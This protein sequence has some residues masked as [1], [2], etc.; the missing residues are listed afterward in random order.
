MLYHCE[1]LILC[2]MLYC[3]QV[4]KD[5]E[6]PFVH[7]L[8]VI[9]RSGLLSTLHDKAWVVLALYNVV[10]CSPVTDPDISKQFSHHNVQRWFG[11][12]PRTVPSFEAPSLALQNQISL[13]WTSK[14]N[15]NCYIITR[16]MKTVAV[17]GEGTEASVVYPAWLKV[18][19]GIKGKYA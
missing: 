16:Q 12:P 2:F 15:K 9:L 6:W 7:W 10:A 4:T 14:L 11:F 19:L 13:V 18:G 1:H 5:C 3:I 17:Q 8:C